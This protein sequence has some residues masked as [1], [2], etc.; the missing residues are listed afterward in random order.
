V[1]QAHRDSASADP[2]AEV[3]GGRQMKAL[4]GEQE[5]QYFRGRDADDYVLAQ[6]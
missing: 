4:N 1:R 6:W 2:S 5:P 3:E